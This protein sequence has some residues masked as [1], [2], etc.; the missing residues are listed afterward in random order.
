MGKLKLCS[1]EGLNNNVFYFSHKLFRVD[2]LR[3]QLA[4]NFAQGPFV[5]LVIINTRRHFEAAVV[6]VQCVVSQVTVYIVHGLLVVGKFNLL[7]L[8][9]G[10]THKSVLIQKNS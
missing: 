7:V 4:E 9:C 8:V 2:I 3:S 6:L 5:A 10:E 1:E